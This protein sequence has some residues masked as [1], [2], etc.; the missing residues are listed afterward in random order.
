MNKTLV[1]A[2]A[3]ALLAA[4]AVSFASEADSGFF[5]N[6]NS[7]ISS[8]RMSQGSN[9]DMATDRNDSAFGVRGGYRWGSVVN[10]GAELGYVH[11]GDSSVN[12]TDGTLRADLAPKVQGLTVGG[13]LQYDFNGSNWFAGMRGG[14]FRARNDL[15][16]SISEGTQTRNSK[17]RYD[18]DGGWYAGANVGYKVSDN[19]RFGLAYD[20]YNNKAQVREAGFKEKYN[21]EMY[22]GFYEYQF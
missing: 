1:A 11:L 20:N 7:G 3:V 19:I 10:Y 5:L 8:N 16:A 15:T 2:L 22:S 12:L 4:P 13:N 21:T 14:W 17:V 18:N 9:K 6:A